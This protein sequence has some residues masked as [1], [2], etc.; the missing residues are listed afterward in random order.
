[1]LYAMKQIKFSIRRDG[2]D[3]IF[4]IY[5]RKNI[6]F[7]F[8]D[9]KPTNKVKSGG[10]EREVISMTYDC[11]WSKTTED[12]RPAIKNSIRRCKI[13]TICVK[14]GDYMTP[15]RNG[16]YEKLINVDPSSVE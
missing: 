6:G 2:I 4:K 8:E 14:E 15:D 5:D 11:T 7:I 1:M 10:V 12:G 3:N 13:S 9:I 16:T